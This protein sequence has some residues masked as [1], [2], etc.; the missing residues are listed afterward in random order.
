MSSDVVGEAIDGNDLAELLRLADAFVSTH[1][2]DALLSLRDRARLA[3]ERGRQ[4][5]PAANYA[6]YRL[7]LDAP[8]EYA[9]Q[10]L[11]E[12]AGRFALGPMAE[13][14]AVRHTWVELA[15]HAPPG[16]VASVAAHERVVRGEPVDVSTVTHP[17]VL[18]VP[19][20]LQRWEPEYYVPEYHADRVEQRGP[21]PV[22][23]RP[24]ELP[25]R[26]PERV[27]D[28]DVA[29]AFR[30]LVRPWTAASEGAARIVAVKGGIGD[31]VAALGM[32]EVRGAFVDAGEALALLGWAGSSGGRH[33]RRRGAASGRDLA[34]AAAGA[35]CG[36]GPGERFEP[37]ALGDAISELRW[38]VWNAPDVS[39][40]WVLRLAAEDPID[41]VAWAVDAVDRA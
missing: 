9:A 31:A 19:L 4:M 8:A 39:T 37:A 10:M 18:G 33:G 40:G 30:D 41:A 20:A 34:W 2:W 7:A 29:Q 12:D 24:L 32:R 16:P 14:A 27:D 38:Y 21:A 35:C 13:V 11:T 25:V 6:E 17:E 1:E 36:F 22:R 3:I 5:W 23:G 28:P 26:A 15:P